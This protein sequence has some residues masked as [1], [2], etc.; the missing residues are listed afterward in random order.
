[1]R[2]GHSGTSVKSIARAVVMTALILAQGSVRAQPDACFDQVGTTVATS[3]WKDIGSYF[4]TLFVSPAQR[5]KAQLI[6]LRASIVYLEVQK[7]RLIEIATAHTIDEVSGLTAARNLAA[8]QIPEI[9]QRISGISTRLNEMA[10]E[11]NLFAAEPAFRQLVLTLDYK[12]AVTLCSLS[13]EAAG[14][15]VDR[16]ALQRLIAELKSEL[17]AIMSAEDALAAYIRKLP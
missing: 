17:A 14:G 9:L 6:S 8:D 3:V 7:Q 15:F 10:Q 11:A 12:R 2:L 5:N 1:M 4:T 16:A 13:R